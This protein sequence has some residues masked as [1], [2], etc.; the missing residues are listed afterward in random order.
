M[1]IPWLGFG[2]ARPHYLGGL[3]HC[4]G[5]ALLAC[6]SCWKLDVRKERIR[7]EYMIG[8]LV[9]SFSKSDTVHV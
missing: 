5:K 6:M 1:R 8:D 4:L 3:C 7:C 9:Q 2:I